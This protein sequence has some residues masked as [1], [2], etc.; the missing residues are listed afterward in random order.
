[1]L[2]SRSPIFFRALAGFLLL[3]LAPS[4]SSVAAP[5]SPHS[6]ATELSA[7]ADDLGS[8]GSTAERCSM[9]D[10]GLIARQIGI[11]L[12]ANLLLALHPEESLRALQAFAAAATRARSEYDAASDLHKSRL[13]AL[14][15]LGWRSTREASSIDTSMPDMRDASDLAHSAG[16]IHG[17]L[18]RC[19]LATPLDQSL[20]K[21]IATQA[22]LSLALAALASSGFDDL[23]AAQ[24]AWSQGFA[25]GLN[26]DG[27]KHEQ[28]SLASQSLTRLAR[29]FSRRPD[30]ASSILRAKANK[31][32][33][34]GTIL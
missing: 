27:F 11:Q 20:G 22:S 24:S 12:S 2:L 4:L 28:C 30:L 14:A 31:T 3:F 9:D 25:Y 17:W 33:L 18:L 1:M 5:H 6:L 7:Q 29:A 26:D 8:L 21:E 23:L 16:A 13:C 32:R 19:H 34:L 10:P 15:W